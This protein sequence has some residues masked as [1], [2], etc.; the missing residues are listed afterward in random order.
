LVCGEPF[1]D[2][3]KPCPACAADNPVVATIEPV[4]AYTVPVD[5]HANGTFT[6]RA[7]ECS[8]SGLFSDA[9]T[10][11]WYGNGDAWA[12]YGER[13]RDLGPELADIH[14]HLRVLD[15]L[16]AAERAYPHG[17]T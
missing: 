11:A 3:G 6:V 12:G 5:V 8:T 4:I 14:P 1:P 10:G 15:V 7:P 9:E 2:D 17:L 13:L 16:Q